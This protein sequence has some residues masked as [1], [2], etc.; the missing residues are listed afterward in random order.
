ML[1]GDIKVGETDDC[2]SQPSEGKAER[3]AGVW[4][5]W[6]TILEALAKEGFKYAVIFNNIV[7]DQVFISEKTGHNSPNRNDKFELHGNLENLG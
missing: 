5:Q 7:E 1:A 2:K 6:L 4:R 3:V